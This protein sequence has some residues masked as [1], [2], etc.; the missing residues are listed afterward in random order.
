MGPIGK[1]VEKLPILHTACLAL[2]NALV[3]VVDDIARLG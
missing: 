3:A 1:R 2:H